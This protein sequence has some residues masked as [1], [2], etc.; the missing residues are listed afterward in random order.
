MEKREKNK[1]KRPLKLSSAGRL[2]LRK[3]LGPSKSVRSKQGEKG[4]TI[5]IIFKN[6]NNQRQ[7]SS[8]TK[9]NVGRGSSMSRPQFSQNLVANKFPQKTSKNFNQKN[10]KNTDSKK[11]QTKKTT[12]KPLS[13]L[14]EKTGRLNVNKVLEQEEQ[15]YQKYLELFN[16]EI[17]KFLNRIQEGT[18]KPCKKLISLVQEF[19]V[20]Q[21]N[22]LE[23]NNKLSDSNRLTHFRKLQEI[24]DIINES[25]KNCREAGIQKIN[26]T[27]EVVGQERL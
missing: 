17:P 23:R 21:E 15:E 3:N 8:A 4:K 10:K 22:Y 20:S 27:Q 26:Q 13:E 1:Q 25:Y 16:K 7:T 12:L 6:K 5:Q 18:N 2:Q 24:N 9:S 19:N 11:N 14:D